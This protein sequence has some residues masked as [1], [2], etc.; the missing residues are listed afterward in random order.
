MATDR[1]ATTPSPTSRRRLLQTAAIAAGATAG[2]GFPAVVRS[3]APIKWRVQSAAY[4]GTAG[5]TQFQK[6]CANIKELSE[7]KLQFQPFPPDAVVG[8]FEMFNAVKGG[9]LDAMHCFT[10]YWSGTM[11][12][13]AFLSS[14]PLALDRPDQWET[15]FYELGG[16]QIARK[17]FRTHNMYYVGPV[18][19]DLNLIHSKVPI[20]SF[21]EF[22]GKRI[23]FP[24]GMIAEIFTQAGVSTVLLTG[25]EVYGALER[26]VIDGADFVGPAVNY[27]LKFGVVAK[28]IIMG[29]PSTPCLHQPVDLMDVTVN[30]ARWTALPKHLQEVVT[31]ATRQHS[32]DHYAYIQKEN[33]AAWEKYKTDGIQVIRLSEEDVQKFRRFAIP[34]WF[35]WAKKDPLARE[36]FASQLAFM[37]TVNVGY[38]PDSMLVDVDGK[39]KLTL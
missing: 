2:L 26:G 8:T 19:H 24:G 25:G 1:D 14:Y 3:Q 31:A 9:V 39:T 16:L 17:A 37:R 21:E 6:Y 33:I 7:G 20:R 28:Y 11:P 32:W 13:A 12:V 27:N 34:L 29:P 35:K 36:A 30:M 10:T 15:W 18:Q 4:A 22:K 38:V 23:R 5:Y